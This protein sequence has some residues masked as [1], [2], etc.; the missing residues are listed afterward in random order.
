V[1]AIATR[2]A[3]LGGRAIDDPVERALAAGTE[4]VEGDALN[5]ARGQIVGLGAWHEEGEIV[6]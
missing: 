1:Q 6:P 4:A 5:E 3:R 2:A